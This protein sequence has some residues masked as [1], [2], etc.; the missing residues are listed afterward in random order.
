M[1]IFSQKKMLAHFAKHPV[2]KVEHTRQT[3]P[4]AHVAFFTRESASALIP[5]IDVALPFAMLDV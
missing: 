2:L 5:E 3:E 4:A 1:R